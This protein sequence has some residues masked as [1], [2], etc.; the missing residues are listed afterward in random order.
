LFLIDYSRIVSV[1]VGKKLSPQST[2]NG[3]LRDAKIAIVDDNEEICS[4]L[5]RMIKTLGLRP[6]IVAHDGKEIVDAVI[7]LG[8]SPDLILIDFRLPRLDGI[9]AGKIISKHRPGVRI[10]LTTSDET[11]KPAAL[12]EGFGFLQKPFS[13]RSF[14]SSICGYLTSR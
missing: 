11:A 7:N 14:T 8:L 2:T 5:S 10:I 6:P 12:R 4:L 1:E 9:E 13:L 3:E